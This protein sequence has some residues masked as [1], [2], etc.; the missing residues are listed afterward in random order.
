MDENIQIA[1]AV[2]HDG[3]MYRGNTPSDAVTLTLFMNMNGP[4]TANRMLFD[5]GEI[6]ILDDTEPFEIAFSN[7]TQLGVV[8]LSKQWVK[9]HF[10]YL[11][12]MLGYVY[13]DTHNTLMPFIMQIRDKTYIHREKLYSQLISTLE[14]LELET[15]PKIKKRLSK[16]EHLIFDIRDYLLENLEE[17]LQV[18]TLCREF[19][20]S[21]RTLQ[22][23]FKHI[24]GYTPKKFIKLLKYNKAYDGIINSD[25]KI[26]QIAMQYGFTNFG[27]FSQ[28]FRQM[29][30]YLP[31]ELRKKKDISL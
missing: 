26:S 31:S 29:F 11:L 21:D 27:L 5:E 8:V 25:I 20:V 16:K 9:T 23:A 13:R 22:T 28:E 2:Y 19:G 18:D 30:G 3:L 10:P 1:N 14:T 7:T 12:D 6:I 24:F 15:Q 4:L 17:P